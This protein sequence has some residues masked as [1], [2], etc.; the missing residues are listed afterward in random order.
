[1]RSVFA[2]LIAAFFCASASAAP[3]PHSILS[4]PTKHGFAVFH[5][6][7]ANDQATQEKGLMFR[8]HMAADAGMLF[9]FHE[10]EYVTFWMKDTILPLDMIF[11]RQDGTIASIAA[12]AKPESLDQIKSPEAI[13][14]VLEINGGR[15]A[16]LGIEPGQRVKAAIFPRH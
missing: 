3:L 1:M 2:A 6:E 5:V 7:V 16:A 13:R 12:N 9:D 4:I 14:A 11:I 8:R 10:P 15:A